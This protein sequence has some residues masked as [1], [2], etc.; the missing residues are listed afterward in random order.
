METSPG[1]DA[2][3][4]VKFVF[5]LSG[6]GLNITFAIYLAYVKVYGEVFSR[7][8]LGWMNV[9]IYTAATSVVFTQILLDRS[10]DIKY[11]TKTSYTFRICLGLFI[12]G[13]TCL[14]IPFADSN[15]LQVYMI[16]VLIGVFEGSGLATLQQL[17]PSIHRDLSKYANTG[18]T[19]AQVLPILLSFL[20]GFYDAK[21]GS[22]AGI[23]FAWIPAGLC[24][25]AS[26]LFLGVV[27]NGTFNSA[28]RRRDETLT[29]EKM[30]SLQNSERTPLADNSEHKSMWLQ[31][32]VLMCASVQFV[33][34]GLSIFLMPFLT[35]FGSSRLAHMLVLVRFGGE[36][37][38]RI[39]SHV[40]GCGLHN[41][42]PRTAVLVLAVATIV[43]SVLLVVSI[44]DIFWRGYFFD[45]E[46]L[47]LFIIV[48]IFYALFGWSQSEVMTTV[49]DV[50]PPEKDGDLARGMM[51]ICF[52]SQLFS[53]A[54]ALTLIEF[55]LEK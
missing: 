22:V 49:I 18:F 1:E 55:V 39:A 52:A 53:L 47:W 25:L 37:A 2:S 4:L 31:Y 8:I 48:G 30:R 10:F 43:R 38:G 19:I 44:V 36:L 46:R 33:T 34:N 13:C 24:L 27:L 26:A 6:L 3:C 14:F 28:F 41:C 16:G 29:N 5:A 35:Y 42:A 9:C 51:C 17:A 12:M 23:A 7:S 20:L 50:G 32:P 15:V 21:A 54:I 11:N 45:M 40:P